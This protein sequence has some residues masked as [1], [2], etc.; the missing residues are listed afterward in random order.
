MRI[1]LLGLLLSVS[2]KVV[3]AT[4]LT[5]SLTHRAVPDA[6]NEREVFDLESTRLYRQSGN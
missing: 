3:F 6:I 1:H 2:L 5:S 4:M